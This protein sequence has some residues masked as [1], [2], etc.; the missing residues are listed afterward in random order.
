ME[1]KNFLNK[2]DIFRVPILLRFK[3]SQ[4]FSSNIT[5]TLSIIT[6]FLGFL[7]CGYSIYELF[8]YQS[9]SIVTNS[10]LNN[11]IID[12]SNTPIL[13]G[14]TTEN[15]E[16]IPL[17]SSIIITSYV[18]NFKTS[19]NEKNKKIDIIE[20][21]EINMEF[22]NNSYY[23]KKYNFI[24][25]Y[26]LSNYLCVKPN[27]NLSLF[28]RHRDFI[29]GYSTINFFLKKLIEDNNFLNNH[30]FSLIYLSEVIDNDQ[31]KNPIIKQFR[32]E[33]FQ[34]SLNS[35]KKFFYS[36]SPLIYN[37][38]EGLFFQIKKK[39]KSF[40]FNNIQLDF[41]NNNVD[42]YSSDDYG[43][44]DKSLNLIKISFTS[45]D[46]MEEVTRKYL[47]FY[48]MCSKIGGTLEVFVGIF[49]FI[50]QYLSRKS[51]VVDFVNQLILSNNNNKI[52]NRINKIYL[53]NLFNKKEKKISQIFKTE[54]RNKKDISN[55][56]FKSEV[57][58]QNERLN[59][60]TNIPIK[61]LNSIYKYQ[62]NFDGQIY[63][64]SFLNYLLPFFYLK[65][66]KRYR[67]LCM[68]SNIIDTFLSLEEILPIIERM[69]KYFKEKKN[70]NFEK[71][72]I[73]NMQPINKS[74]LPIF[75]I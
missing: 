58:S 6:I 71:K 33:N 4:H 51:L 31:Y 20:Y 41:L 49:Y 46:F 17:N 48:E 44:D 45:I 27:Q 54:F 50:S 32:S 61:N 57:N 7:Y 67:I 28:G 29:N 13:I 21:N 62:F 35:Y 39:Y 66:K 59:N 74:N 24:Q 14:I 36:F 52:N 12:L 72:Y 30:F 40:S 22:C 11:E 43:S 68:Y 75:Y 9:F 70:T 8:S 38:N 37:S 16:S 73:L 60:N 10:K 1:K 18:K 2:I 55:I 56:I 19:L 5:K 64:I 53:S 26:N 69:S 25:K 42:D 23:I 3:K 47:D 65:K 15:G 63:T 34:I